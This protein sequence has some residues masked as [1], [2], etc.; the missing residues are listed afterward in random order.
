VAA[1]LAGAHFDFIP[2]GPFVVVRGERPALRW[3]IRRFAC[4][5]TLPRGTPARR[6][7]F[8]AAA[9]GPLAN[10][11]LGLGA[12]GLGFAGAGGTWHFLTPLA[13]ILSG[14]F[15]ALHGLVF[16]WPWRPY[17]VPSDGV[18]LL[19]LLRNTSSARRWIA[20]QS[21]TGL[22]EQG[23][24]PRDWL[25]L[26]ALI[27]PSDGS[28]DDVAGALTLYWHLLDSHRLAEARTC[29][30]QARAAASQHYMAQVNSQLVLL[31]LAYL[32]ARAGTDPALAV[33]NLLDSRFIAPA[34]LARVIGTIQ[35]S[36]G[37]FA[38]AQQTAE[39]ARNDERRM[40]RGY[41]LMERDLLSSL[42]DEAQRRRDG[43]SASVSTVSALT[44]D[45]S[46]FPDQVL[47]QP[48]PPQG[49]RSAR[50]VVGVVSS[51]MLGLIAY[52]VVAA[53]ARP[54]AMPVAVAASLLGIL[55]VLRVRRSSGR[56]PV[57]AVRVL[58]AGL[59]TVSVALPVLVSALFTSNASG[60]IWIAG[61][62][63]PCTTFGTGHDLSSLPIYLFALT[64]ISLG[65]LLGTR[66]DREPLVPRV[67]IYIGGALLIAWIITIGADHAPLAAMLGCG[68]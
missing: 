50:T 61:Q 16:L 9:G 41:A 55:A 62:A 56:A 39:A 7:L 44:L 28:T 30:E 8:V 6:Q 60:Y 49:L 26:D 35:L 54:A 22:S 67:G 2:L 63:R 53:F 3:Q 65:L 32:E 64:F 11:A 24:R 68:R 13:L 38:N 66:A 25:H 47:R 48:L 21:I 12:A 20:I 57:R 40:R 14:T 5:A 19:S 46:G 43:L 15:C 51:A 27:A 17:G 1:R 18:R 42:I 31:E 45:V 34:A 59:A 29:L 4:G 37:R 52:V 33:K 58:F 36:Y 23:V 10:I